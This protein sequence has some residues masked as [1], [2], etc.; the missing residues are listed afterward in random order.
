MTDL[1]LILGARKKTEPLFL[2]YKGPGSDIRERSAL[3]G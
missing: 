2:G 3:A 1:T